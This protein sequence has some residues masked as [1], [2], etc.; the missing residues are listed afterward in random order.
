MPTT[1]SLL[2]ALVALPIFLAIGCQT[3]YRTPGGPAPIGEMTAPTIAEKLRVQPESPMPATLAL[4]RVQGGN[5]YSR[6]VAG[7]RRGGVSI[8]SA[9][10]LEVPEDVWSI[11]KWPMVRF[12]TR[13][14]AIIIPD[15]K[16]TDPNAAMLALRE[17]AATLHADILALYTI[18][19]T[20]RVDDFSPGALGLVTL[21]LA[22]TKNA[23]VNATASMVFVDVR[24]GFV[25]GTAEA[26]AR[27]D[28]IA[29]S[30]TSGDAVDQCRRRVEREALTAMLAEAE[31]CWAGIAA[32]R[33][34][35]VEATGLSETVAPPGNA[36]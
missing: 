5:Y 29:N 3:Y 12:A 30:W 11:Q 14:S 22:P 25:Y 13:L 10:D 36:K 26:S 4:V 16:P 15:A 9:D 7:V 34:T 17:G 1:R 33:K 28:Q 18:D 2:L 8:V 23:V 20:F 6:S 32:G 31:K 24:T 21:G 19:T 27:D 35:Q